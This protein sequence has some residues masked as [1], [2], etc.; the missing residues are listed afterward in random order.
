MT[1]RPGTVTR[2]D[3]GRRT[4]GVRRAGSESRPLVS[5]VTVV[6]NRVSHIEETILAILGQSY[7]NL[8]YIVVDGGSTDGTVDILRRYDDRIDYWVSE[9]DTGIYEAM[10][11]GIDLVTESES[12]VMFANSDDRLFSP[13]VVQRI[14]ERGRGADLVYG[15][16][17]VTDGGA[18]RITGREVTFNDLAGETLNHPAT[19]TRRR[20][21]DLVGKFDTSYRIAADYDQ[22][23]RCFAH[24]V[25]TQFVDEIVSRMSMHGT[26]EAQFRLSCRERK[27]VVREHY[28]A[29]TRLSG[30]LSVNLY[31]LPR[32]SAR[33]WLARTGL[34][35]RW[36]ALKGF[37]SGLWHWISP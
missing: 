1:V 32:S 12:Y 17:Q 35:D 14:V 8:E 6:L 5:I 15:K 2:A 33:Y 7:P 21:F 28:R 10:N 18:S 16:M 25:T 31:A 27:R 29:V 19:F 34:L 13:Q 22:I 26:S 37:S 4:R 9:P 11:K 30:I 24:P 3:G 36:R 20:V 23:V